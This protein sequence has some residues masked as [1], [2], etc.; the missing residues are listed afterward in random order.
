VTV[1]LPNPGKGLRSQ[2]PIVLHAQLVWGEARGES[3]EAKLAVAYTPMNRLEAGGF[4]RTFLDVVLKPYQYSSLR[5][6]AANLEKSLHPLRYDSEQVW[7]SCVLAATLAQAGR[8]PDPSWG[9]V[10][11]HDSSLSRAPKAWG[12]VVLTVALGHLRFYKPA[13]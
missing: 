6:T 3:D 11:C 8:V 10:F 5:A 4:G 1:L 7:V 13:R 12:R 9:A 2:N